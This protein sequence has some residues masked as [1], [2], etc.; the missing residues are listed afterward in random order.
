MRRYSAWSASERSGCRE[1][2]VRALPRLRCAT[3]HPVGTGASA[4]S[5]GRSRRY[6][7]EAT[8][9]EK[10]L[11]R[12]RTITA[13]GLA[14][15]ALLAWYYTIMVASMSAGGMSGAAS[16]MAMPQDHPWSR[17]DFLLMFVMWMVM[18]VAMMLPS[19]SPMIL[20]FT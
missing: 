17:A 1:A 13:V 18:M 9:L 15:I 3:G 12:D 19:A 11:R 4:P 2:T 7:L 14:A 20:V 8:T 6:M 5:A 16:Q 10:V